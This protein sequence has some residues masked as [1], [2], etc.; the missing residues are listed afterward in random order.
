M[1]YAARRV[2]IPGRKRIPVGIWQQANG[3]GYRAADIRREAQFLAMNGAR[4]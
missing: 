1:T 4:P 2:S 3:Q